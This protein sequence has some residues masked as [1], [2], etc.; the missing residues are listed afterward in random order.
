MASAT[1][2][3]KDYADIL[4]ETGKSYLQR[5]RA[6]S[7][8]MSQLIDALLQLSRITRKEMMVKGINLSH[9]AS[10]ISKD[11]QNNQPERV[12][13]WVIQP[14]VVM[15]GDPALIRIALT[16][17]LGNAW[18]FTMK[19]IAP[20]I[21]FGQTEQEGRTVYYVRDNGAGFD[22]T[23]ADKL[24]RAFQTPAFPG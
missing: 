23:Y 3:W 12:V 8:H 11:L 21:E 20:R 15:A 22:M 14:N 7:Q 24:F 9:M 5:I 19:T 13:E 6:A 16:N 10:E 18:K 4:D 1:F 2:C 17:L